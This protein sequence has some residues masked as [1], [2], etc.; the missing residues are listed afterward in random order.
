MKRDFTFILVLEHLSHFDVLESGELIL[1]DDQFSRAQQTFLLLSL[2]AT[3]MPLFFLLMD[4]KRVSP[5]AQDRL[6]CTSQC[7]FI[8]DSAFNYSEYY[9]IAVFVGN[10]RLNTVKK[11]IIIAINARN[12]PDHCVL[13]HIAHRRCLHVALGKRFNIQVYDDDV[14]KS[15]PFRKP[16]E[17]R[18]SAGFCVLLSLKPPD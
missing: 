5:L 18:A 14:T 15:E 17:V 12:D 4:D 6:S 9:F 13:V 8:P 11:M 2:S 16:T 1:F 7:S 10:S 3:S